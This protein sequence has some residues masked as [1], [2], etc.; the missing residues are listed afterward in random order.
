MKIIVINFCLCGMSKKNFKK[1]IMIYRP[2]KIKRKVIFLNKKNENTNLL[3]I[4]KTLKYINQNKM[5]LDNKNIYLYYKNY[6]LKVVKNKTIKEI[7][8][9][10]NH[11]FFKIYLFQIEGGASIHNQGYDFRIHP[12]EHIHKHSPHV[13]VVKNNTSV[14]YSLQTFE[15]Y[16]NDNVSKEIKKDEKKVIIPFIKKKQKYFLDCWNHYINGFEPPIINENNKQF[17]EES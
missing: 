14:R 3:E 12:D 17:Y 11:K 15:R 9:Y 8:D 5:S 4:V 1:N 13:H 7:S 16:K 2:R 6:L 10:I